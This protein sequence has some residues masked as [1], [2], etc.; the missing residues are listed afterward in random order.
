LSTSPTTA[1]RRPRVLLVRLN[2][3]SFVAKDLAILQSQYDVAEADCRG[4][5]GVCR[6]VGAALRSDCVYCW[7]GS[8]RFL[9]AILAARLAGCP[10]V[11]VTGG[12]DVARVPEIGYGNMVPFASRWLGRLLFRLASLV[13]PFSESG[14]ADSRDH[15]RVSPARIRVVPLGYDGSDA[16]P[17]VPSRPKQP[18]VLTVGHADES[19]IVRKGMLSFVR[20][21]GRIPEAS[22]ILAGSGTSAAMDL[23]RGEAAPNVRFAGFVEPSELRRLFAEAA[24]YLQTSLHEGFGSAVAEAMLYDCIPVVAPRFALLEVVGPC[25]L[26]VEPGDLGAIETAVRA[27]LA[28]E[29][30]LP[31]SPRRRILREFSLVSRKQAILDA[32]S[33]LVHR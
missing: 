17:L 24:V 26:Y 2:L 7:F 18:I 15:A 21:A 13:L 1:G 6:S 27:A 19:T 33:P 28:G 9:P 14:A 29:V 3:A 8:L 22:F 31:E 20:V 32:V 23:L 10:V 12:Y 25:G 5:I 30:S 11:V 16:P 4:L